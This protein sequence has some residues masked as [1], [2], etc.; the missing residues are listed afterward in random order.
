MIGIGLALF[1]TGGGKWSIDR[2]NTEKVER[3][4]SDVAEDSRKGWNY[5]H[6]QDTSY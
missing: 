1:I 5:E 3:S 4:T 6:G 2:L